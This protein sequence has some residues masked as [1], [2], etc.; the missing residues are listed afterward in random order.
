MDWLTTEL[1]FELTTIEPASSDASFRRYFR[2]FFDDRPHIVMDAPPSHEDLEP[3]LHAADLL[4]R[5]GMNVPDIFHKNLDHGFLLLEDFGQCCYLDKLDADNATALYRSAMDSLLRLQRNA[6]TANSGLP[7]YDYE[8]LKTEL[9]LFRN[10]FLDRLLNIDLSEKEHALIDRTWEFLIKSAL[11]QP[12]VCVHRDFHSRNLMYLEQNNPGVIDFQ[13]AVVGPLTYDLVSLLRDCYIS[14]PDR[15]VEEWVGDYHRRITESGIDAGSLE[16]FKRWFDLMGVQ[17]HLKATGI[18][19]R[20][21]IRDAKPGYLNDIP[22]TMNYV[23][24]TGRRY[25]ELSDFLAFLND[26]VLPLD[27]LSA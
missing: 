16:R 24:E 19:S 2:A 1:R 3:F 7:K 4:N 20:L 25:S 6:D 14:W 9:E 21:K 12:Q 15:L 13:D 18:F 5:A 26:K 17:R 10:W 11:E 23:V 8:L 22:R 27:R